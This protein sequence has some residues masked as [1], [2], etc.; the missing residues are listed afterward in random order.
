MKNGARYVVTTRWGTFSLDEGSYRDYLEGRH[1]ICWNSDNTETIMPKGNAYV[2]PNVS[3][4]AVALRDRADRDGII[5]TLKHLGL[6][7][8]IVP[9]TD[10][11]VDLSID[12]MNLTVRAR[13][14]LM[15][16]NV[17]TLG[18]LRDLLAKENGILSIRNLGQKSAREIKHA[19]FEECYA[20]LPPHEKAQ[21]WQEMLDKRSFSC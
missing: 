7:E 12:E 11:L 5:E 18:R 21:Y 19:F 16:A 10:R 13:N 20:R 2:P 9:Y 6:R 8:A 15:R 17:T 1:W 3:A 14:G 4:Q